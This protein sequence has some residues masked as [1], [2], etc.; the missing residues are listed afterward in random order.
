MNSVLTEALELKNNSQGL[1]VEIIVVDDGSK[2]R[3]REMLVPF[4]DQI[5]IIHHQT[6]LGYGA[7]LKTGLFYSN[8]ET[9][10]FMDFDGTCLAAEALDLYHSL[11]R[12]NADMVMGYRLHEK[13]H[14]PPT[15]RVGNRMYLAL[16]K[17][18]YFNRKNLPKDACTG[19]R[20]LKKEAAEKL[21]PNLPN[22]LSFSPALTSKALKNGMTLVDQKI[23]YRERFGT[24][25]ISVLKDGLKFGV[26]MIQG[27]LR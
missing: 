13:S 23:T 3:S 26:A 1:N 4:K 27:R 7:A 9:V 22:D 18:L 21:F 10:A 19:F 6:N 14:M 17:G 16:L 24:S 20:L 8:G 15:R 5:R 2:D 11:K 12:E 25:K